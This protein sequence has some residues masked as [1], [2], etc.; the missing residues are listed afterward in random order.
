MITVARKVGL[1]GLGNLG[2]PMAKNLVKAGF[3]V[4]VYDV[5]AQPMSVL[6]NLGATACA[7][8][9]EVGSRCD[10]IFTM[11]LNLEQTE[12][13][14]FG[15]EGV[16]GS[17]RPGSKLVIGSTLGPEPVH[18]IAEALRER[19][20]DVVD[21][22]VAGGH[23]SAEKG[24]LTMMIGAD[25]GVFEE[26]LPVLR[27]VGSKIIRTGAVG[28]AQT[29]KLANNLILGINIIALLEG[30]ELGIAGGIAPETLREVFRNASARSYPLEVWDELGSRWKGML[31]RQGAG[32][33]I[34]MRKDLALAQ[35]YARDVGVALVLGSAASAIW[36]GTIAA[37][38]SDPYETGN[39]D[40]SSR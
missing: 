36:K 29:A 31:A 17:M 39:A 33:E 38:Y 3:E 30:L 34:P 12:A 26:V 22:P 4:A 28:T 2:E 24:T 16:S 27:A 25:P 1:I 11:V 14:V 13:V 6:A 8:P 20:I 35:A 32:P 40:S 10:T 9:A 23:P 19:G 21:A 37:T 5:R 15:P 7:S 18:R